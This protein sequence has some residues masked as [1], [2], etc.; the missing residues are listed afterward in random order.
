MA[1]GW[2]ICRRVTNC[3]RRANRPRR[4][5]RPP[6]RPPLRPGSDRVSDH[7]RGLDSGDA[8]RGSPGVLGVRLPEEGRL[9]HA[10]GTADS[11]KLRHTLNAEQIAWFRAGGALNK[12]RAK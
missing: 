1:A 12:L 8:E 2:H 7:A 3:P 10:D 6:L 9:H 11:V 4:T 5:I